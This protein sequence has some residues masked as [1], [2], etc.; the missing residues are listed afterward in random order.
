MRYFYLHSLKGKGCQCFT[1]VNNLLE[2]P[3][4]FVSIE[5]FV[6]HLRHQA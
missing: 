6:A 4:D 5:D 1:Y 3:L 2:Q